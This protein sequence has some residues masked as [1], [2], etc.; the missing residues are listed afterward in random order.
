MLL[1]VKHLN[2]S[3]LHSGLM[4]DCKPSSSMT[5]KESI[6]VR[7]D[8]QKLVPLCLLSFF[9]DFYVKS[10]FLKTSNSLNFLT[11]LL[12]T[13][14]SLFPNI[15]LFTLPLLQGRAEWNGEKLK[16]EQKNPP[17]T[18]KKNQHNLHSRVKFAMRIFESIFVQF[19]LDKTQEFDFSHCFPLYSSWLRKHRLKPILNHNIQL[20]HREWAGRRNQWVDYSISCCSHDLLILPCTTR[21][22]VGK[23]SLCKIRSNCCIFSAHSRKLDQ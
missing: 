15:I 20:K 6:Y 12:G 10:E 3:H 14:K 13:R 2:Y 18:H 23:W 19:H 9:C 1:D 21:R 22:A 11:C 16:A 4:R 8:W 17:H 5:Q 7:G